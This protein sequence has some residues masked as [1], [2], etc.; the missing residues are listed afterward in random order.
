MG[1]I[2]GPMEIYIKIQVGSS[3]FRATGGRKRLF[4]GLGIIQRERV[5]TPVSLTGE[6]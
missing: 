6:A 4:G 3:I 2:P 5:V 1:L